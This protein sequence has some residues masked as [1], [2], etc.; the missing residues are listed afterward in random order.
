MIDWND[1]S[2][3]LA[4]AREGSTAAAARALKVNQSTVSRRIAVLEEG[5]GVRLFDKSRDGY[6]LT[7]A[8]AELVNNARTIDESVAAFCRRAASFDTRL[9]GSL[10]LSTAEGIAYRLLPP[11]LRAF[12]EQHPGLRINLVLED[13]F[14][15][16]SQGQADIALRAAFDTDGRTA[17]RGAG[18]GAVIG[19]KLVDGAWAVYASR[20]YVGRHGRPATPAALNSHRLIGFEGTLERMPVSRWLEAVAPDGTIAMR[21]SGIIAH[22]MAVKSG[23]GAALLPCHVGDPEPDLVRVIPPIP[24]LQ[25]EFWLLTHTDLHKT[26]KVRAFF[27][28]MAAAIKKYRPLLMGETYRGGARERAAGGPEAA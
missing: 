23:A 3:F 19:R 11:L 28:F 2:Y 26:P 7:S 20:S 5:L 17:L 12:Q 4:V 1:L 25:G 27:D 10:R 21:S 13:R 8:G 15:D 24:E 6:R 9:S 18:A 16:L 14:V 22:L